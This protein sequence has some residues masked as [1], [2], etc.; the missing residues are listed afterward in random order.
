MQEN[1][2][3][4]AEPQEAILKPPCRKA[5]QDKQACNERL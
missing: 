5:Y 1:T 2:Q 4:K 3:E